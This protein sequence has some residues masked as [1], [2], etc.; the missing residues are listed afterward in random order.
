M[1]TVIVPTMWRLAT[2]FVNFLDILSDCPLVGE[3]I[4][5]DND[6]SK[7]PILNNPKIKLHD[8]NRNIYVN[9][10]WNFGVNISQYEKI[11]ILN[12][13][14]TFDVKLFDILSNKIE[15]RYGVFGLYPGNKNF[16][17]EESKSNK[18]E[19]IPQTKMRCMGFGCLMFLNKHNWCNIPN[20]LQIFYGDDFIF[21]YNEYIIKKPNFIIKNL[22]FY[23]PY[24]VTSNDLSIT[25]GFMEREKKYY[26][27]LSFTRSF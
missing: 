17:Q 6:N 3:I 23:T 24:S 15:S 2:Q 27:S 25:N 4:I 1:Y 18:I 10:A 21:D 16:G 19:I 9:P 11:C 26:N 7:R 5:I 22:D 20:E 14:I 13:D 8:F 12:D